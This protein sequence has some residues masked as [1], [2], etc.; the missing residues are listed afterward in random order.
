M[1]FVKSTAKLV[2]VTCL[3]AA[4]VYVT[5]FFVVGAE[6]A[7]RRL[8]TAITVTIAEAQTKWIDPCPSCNWVGSYSTEA[9]LRALPQLAEVE[10]YDKWSAAVIVFAHQ[11][12]CEARFEDGRRIYVVA[13][14]RPLFGTWLRLGHL[15]SYPP[16]A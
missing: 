7:K 10:C 14:W 16:D 12:D 2:L 9:E 4:A 3:A 5:T 1:H 13:N 15:E 11:Y 6:G 8:E